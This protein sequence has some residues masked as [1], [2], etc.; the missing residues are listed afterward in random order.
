[1]VQSAQNVQEIDSLVVSD[2]AAWVF[3]PTPPVSISEYHISVPRP[4]FDGIPVPVNPWRQD[5]I[6]VLL[7]ISAILCAIVV[8]F[9]RQLLIDIVRVLSFGTAGRPVTDSRG[10]FHWQTTIANTASFINLSIFLYLLTIYFRVELPAN[11][12]GLVLFA[13]LFVAV[14]I[15]ITARHF[16][17]FTAGIISGKSALFAEYLN[18]I[19]TLYRL[20]GLTIMPVIIAIG[21]FSF[22][23]EEL[24]VKVGIIIIISIF[25]I[26]IISLLVIFIRSN[27]SIFYFILYLCALEILPGAILYRVFTA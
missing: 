23:S 27:I 19:Y 3:H 16:V 21:Y 11:P 25:I 14:A 8:S 24:L 4:L 1:M 18:N 7:L 13:V 10:I 5:W 9:S 22:V 12:K 20:L 15:A 6:T 26:R 17:S 2:T